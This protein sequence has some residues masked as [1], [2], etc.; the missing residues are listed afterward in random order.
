MA[1][2]ANIR[3]TEKCPCGAE[4]TVDGPEYRSDRHH[5][6]PRGA[7]EIVER[8]RKD[9]KHELPK[10]SRGAIADAVGLTGEPQS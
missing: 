1:L 3:I 10:V 2:D 5:A 4:I 8:W 9:H 7:E 6:N